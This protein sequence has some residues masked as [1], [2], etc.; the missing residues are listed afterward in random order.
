LSL[1]NAIAPEHLE[2][3]VKD[4]RGFAR[5]VENAGLVLVGK[6]APCAASDYCIGT[7]H[8]IPT[9]GYARLRTG[10]SAL[11]FV[12]LNWVAEGSREGLRSVLPSLKSLAMAEGL[13]NHY[14]SAESRFKR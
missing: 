5:Q 11:D 2:L 4:A 13:P 7:D 3:L 8:V 12:K 9:E 6:F 14:R 1:V 10:L